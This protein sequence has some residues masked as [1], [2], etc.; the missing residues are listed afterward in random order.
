MD[1]KSRRPVTLL[2]LALVFREIL[3]R[4]L[5]KE[6]VEHRLD[7]WVPYWY[8]PQHFRLV[9][10][11]CLPTFNIRSFSTNQKLFQTCQ[12]ILVEAD[13]IVFINFV[14][15]HPELLRHNPYYDAK[16]SLTGIVLPDEVDN[17]PVRLEKKQVA[18]IVRGFHRIL[19][20]LRLNHA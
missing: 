15:Y 19:P 6:M 5:T 17:I 1:P 3:D 2:E 13:P 9:M 20:E 16:R 4:N 12:A 14:G 10:A 18:K 11:K 7:G 8:C